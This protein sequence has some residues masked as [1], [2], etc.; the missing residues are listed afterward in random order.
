MWERISESFI[1]GKGRRVVKC[2]CSCG[3]VAEVI[4]YNLDKGVSKSCG[5]VN[6]VPKIK[7]RLRNIWNNMKHRC[8]SDNRKDSHVYS[9]KGIKIC[10][11]WLNSFETFYSWSL[12]NNYDNHLQIDRINPDED[13]CPDNCRWVEKFENIYNRYI[14]N[15]DRGIFYCK[16]DKLYRVRFYYNNEVVYCKYFKSKEAAV[17]KRKDLEYF[18]Y[19]YEPPK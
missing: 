19:G 18:Y 15:E 3:K 1:N 8:Y 17:E 12:D 7:K 16:R 10:E 9:E 6:R 4:E 13:Y 11:E 14:N 2:L 5:C